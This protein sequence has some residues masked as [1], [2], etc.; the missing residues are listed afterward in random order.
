MSLYGL[1]RSIWQHVPDGMQDLLRRS[2]VVRGTNAWLR[3]ALAA[4]DELYTPEF[5]EAVDR[6]ALASAGPIADTIARE[7]RPENVLDVGCGTGALL[8]A[9]RD[10]GVRGTGL[11]Y[12]AAGLAYCRARSLEVQQFDLETEQSPPIAP[13]YDVVVSMEVAE[14]LPERLADPLVD[15][16]GGRGSTIVFSAAVPGQGGVDHVNEQPHAYWIAKFAAR[17]LHYDEP[18]SLRWREAWKAQG[19]AWFYHSNLMLFRQ[20]P[21]SQA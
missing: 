2:P 14:H 9:L 4:H 15:L 18:G 19:V 7:L 8:V 3:G 10:R 12:S 21:T 17:G 6:E 5:Y 1:L 16:I 11:E 13:H 20:S